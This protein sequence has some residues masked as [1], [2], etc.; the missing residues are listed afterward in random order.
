MNMLTLQGTV[1]NVFDTPA[2]TDKKTGEV[3]PAATRIQLLTENTLQNGQ[4][5]S[6]LVNLKVTNGEVYRKLVG[7]PVS[8]PVGCFAANNAV[9]FYALN[10][11]SVEA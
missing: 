9:L 8:V 11:E 1:H 7:K 3:F 4:R 10:P 6:E 2:R 5:R